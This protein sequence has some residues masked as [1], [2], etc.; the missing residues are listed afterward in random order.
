MG[1][2]SRLFDSVNSDATKKKK[3]KQS[4]DDS[5]LLVDPILTERPELR[6]RKISKKKK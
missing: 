5:H 2:A 6:I 3:V 1:I 4:K